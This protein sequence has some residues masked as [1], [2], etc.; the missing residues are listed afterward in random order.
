M[1]FKRRSPVLVVPLVAIAAVAWAWYPC[2]LVGTRKKSA[3][4]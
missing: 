2:L 3:P 1:R 4:R